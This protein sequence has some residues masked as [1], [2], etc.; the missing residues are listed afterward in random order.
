MLKHVWEVQDVSC[1]G[2]SPTLSE[3]QS[4]QQLCVRD[5]I[6]TTFQKSELESVHKHLWYHRE[7]IWWNVALNSGLMKS[8]VN[9]F[10]RLEWANLH[11]ALTSLL[12]IRYGGKLDNK[13]KL[14]K[15]K[16]STRSSGFWN[17]K[18]INWP[19]FSSQEYSVIKK[20]VKGGKYKEINEKCKIFT[21]NT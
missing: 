11:S 10:S 17:R 7:S 8:S 15:N 6:L 19:F 16:F 3:S 2:Y 5:S 13:Q 12:H 20:I 4:S 1:F 18:K 14:F 21:K 9:S